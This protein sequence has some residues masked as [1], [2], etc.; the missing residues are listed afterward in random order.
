M[1]SIFV[2]IAIGVIAG[3][4]DIIPMIIQK[5]DR[6]AIVSAFLQYIFV[7]IVIVNIDLP[8]IVWWLQGGI[9][10]FALALPIIAII[11]GSDKKAA[12][13]IAIMSIILG[14]VI[15]IAGHY[16]R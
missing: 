1:K 7:S 5:L 16:L 8:G 4:I 9:I 3:T 14:T 15:G 2:S 11:S 10:S 6:R 12:P 13:I